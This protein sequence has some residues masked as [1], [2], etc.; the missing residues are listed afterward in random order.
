VP[1]HIQQCT[2]MPAILLKHNIDII[3]P[4]AAAMHGLPA[5]HTSMTLFSKKVVTE[6]HVLHTMSAS[7]CR[8]PETLCELQEPFGNPKFDPYTP[9]VHQSPTKESV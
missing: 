5:A 4:Q 3:N 1:S 6:G 2:Y 7:M 9:P 8:T